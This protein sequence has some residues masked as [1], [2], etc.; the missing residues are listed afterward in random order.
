MKLLVVDDHEMLRDALCAY[1]R[2]D[3]DFTVAEAEDVPSALRTIRREGGFDIVLLDF[4]LP[5]MDGLDGLR[6]V[7]SANGGRPVA[8]FSGTANADV[9]AAALRCGAAAFL[10]KTMPL[11]ELK[12]ELRNLATAGPSRWAPAGPEAA[13]PTVQ[14]SPR[15]Q[16]VLEG[17]RSG[18]SSADLARDLGLNE[19]TVRMT[20]KLLFAKLRVDDQ[21]RTAC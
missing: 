7:V 21:A 10:S 16:Q 11:E 19:A 14:L 17:I 15:Q 3:P 18:R 12:I 8:L 2:N 20:M 13:A 9:G 4:Q 5:G 1:L 6:E